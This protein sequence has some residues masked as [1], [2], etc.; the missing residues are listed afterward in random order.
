MS[1]Q[2]D[3]VKKVVHRIEPKQQPIVMS[4]SLGSE[5][6]EELSNLPKTVNAQYFQEQASLENLVEEGWGQED[7]EVQV[8]RR[9]LLACVVVLAAFFLGCA[10]W[11]LVL[12]NDGEE[13]V[14]VEPAPESTAMSFEE[15]SEMRNAAIA[16]YLAATTVQEKALY[17]RD[18]ERVL[19]LMEEYYKKLPVVS[20]Q[21]RSSVVES[22]VMGKNGVLWRVKAREKDIHGSI[23]LLVE[24]KEDGRSLVDW[25]TDV[26]YQPSDWSAF[27]KAKSTEVH[28]FRARVQIA[29]LDGFH[30]FEF[31]EYNRFR[32]FK[33]TL[34]G[35]DDYLWAYTEIGSKEDAKM[36]NLITS[37]GRRSINTKRT[38][39]AILELRYPEGGQ[40]GRC[41]HLS[42]LVQAGWLH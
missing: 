15:K 13:S 41:V 4:N 19:P 36:V 10:V 5:R 28:A 3:T 14:L 29:Q 37:G 9:S 34:P 16:A 27:K 42:R 30:G 7:T 21:M 31:S 22:P 23:H 26:I 35:S 40:S 17:V 18:P 20:E 39:P 8:G 11:A 6:L 12:I 2:E 38:I 1:E 32:C 24:T 25:E 33:V